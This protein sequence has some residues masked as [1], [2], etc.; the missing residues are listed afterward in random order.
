MTHVR[1][2]SCLK[3]A[4]TMNPAET[5]RPNRGW[6]IRGNTARAVI[7]RGKNPLEITMTMDRRP[8]GKQ[9]LTLR[10]Q[11]AK[12]NRPNDVK[13]VATYEFGQGK[14]RVT[15]VA[16]MAA[17]LTAHEVAAMLGIGHG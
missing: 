15:T 2:V 10:D 12:E 8:N 14:G 17:T 1:H 9:V 16:E 4:Q 3:P 13:A 11:P 7:H 6:R 5:N